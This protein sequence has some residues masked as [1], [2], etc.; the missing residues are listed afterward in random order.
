[1]RISL[2]AA[3][4]LVSAP[5]P[6]Q[7][8]DAAA[9]ASVFVGSARKYH[10]VIGLRPAAMRL[11]VPLSAAVRYEGVSAFPVDPVDSQQ[12]PDPAVDTQLRAGLLFT[13][14]QAWS[15]LFITAEA[16][17][18]ILTGQVSGGGGGDLEAVDAPLDGDTDHHL[19][20]GYGRL[21]MGPF[22]TLAGGYMV[23][24]WGLGLLANSGAH[25]WE[26]GSAHF[27]DPRGGDRVLRT[28]VASGPWTRSKLFFVVG[29]DWVQEDDVTLDGD[30]ATQFVA[31]ATLGF[32]KKRSIGAYVAAR[33]QEADDGQKTEVIA[34][35]IYGKWENRV[36][37]L[38]YETELEAALVTGTTELAPTTDFET[39]D[40]LQLGVAARI[41]LDWGGI[42]AVVD[43]LFASGDQNFEDDTQN[44]FK[45]DPNF[46]MGLLLYRHVLAATTARA[47]IRAADPEVVGYAS[48]DL[49]RFP[50]RGSASNTHAI[51]PRGW[52]RPLDGL[53]VYGGPLFAFTDVP[54][55]DPRE[56]K[57]A[58]GQ[59]R[60][61]Y[62]GDG[63]G[64][65]GTELDLGLRYRTL[66]GGTELTVG[67]EGGVFLPG[68]AYTEGEDTSLDRVFGG[69]AMLSYRL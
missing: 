7:E 37:S 56:S 9:E 69:R 65:L 22:L 32:Q 44:A 8:A 68:S 46:E 39:H 49:E 57:F 28:L 66:L 23:S 25:G 55:A 67:F 4:L 43:Y 15:P 50:T 30:E 14:D 42:G 26:P 5:A 17:Y 60:N 52:Y 53:E 35:D 40:I 31:S 54:L 10:P 2:L 61:A 16:E 41:G 11:E 29:H 18:E 13:T 36:G 58:G 62:N 20:K 47:P 6:A 24:H 3:A 21:T 64:Y 27:G 48:E 63:G 38:R 51:F 19:R 12:A 45:P 34:Y 33:T 1:M 59:P